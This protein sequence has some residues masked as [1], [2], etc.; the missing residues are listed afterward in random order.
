MQ[1]YSFLQETQELLALKE[2]PS[3]GDLEA[4]LFSAHLSPTKGPQTAPSQPSTTEPS[5]QEASRSAAPY[6]AAVIPLL[7]VVASD[8]YSVVKDHYIEKGG[9]VPAQEKDLLDGQPAVKEESWQHV[10]SGIFAGE[11]F[12][13]IVSARELLVCFHAIIPTGELEFRAVA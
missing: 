10:C 9:V 6:V 3:L 2:V 4:S 1:V 11:P 13:R 7:Q 5:T 8:I 12:F